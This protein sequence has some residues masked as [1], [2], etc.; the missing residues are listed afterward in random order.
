MSVKKAFKIL[1]IN[2][3]TINNENIKKSYNKLIKY[4]HP[5][6]GSSIYIAGKLNEA[7]SILINYS[8][9][10]QDKC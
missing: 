3:N 6:R 1:N 10:N 5:D 4:N 2:F 7:C 9:I 8:N